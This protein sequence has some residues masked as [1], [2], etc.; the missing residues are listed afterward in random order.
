MIAE[1]E[2]GFRNREC[3]AV[4]ESS[5]PRLDGRLRNR[6]ADRADGDYRK[7][8][9]NCRSNDEP[10]NAIVPHDCLPSIRLLQTMGDCVAKHV[11]SITAG[12][13]FPAEGPESLDG[14]ERGRR[15]SLPNRWGNCDEINL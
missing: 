12:E 9:R 14:S 3:R 1:P 11:T 10:R 2:F 4:G 5:L 13:R 6:T 8:N 15:R 7:S